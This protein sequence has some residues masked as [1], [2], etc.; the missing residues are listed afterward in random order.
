[1]S[2]VDDSDG[3][4]LGVTSLL[5]SIGAEVAAVRAGGVGV[6]G[7]LLLGRVSAAEL[8]VQSVAKPLGEM[9]TTRMPNGS[10]SC[11]SES[12]SPSTANFDALYHEKAAKERWPPIEETLRMVPGSF[13]TR[14]STDPTTATR[15]LELSERTEQILASRDWLPPMKSASRARVLVAL[16]S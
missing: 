6:V 2:N 11:A 4:A 16:E 14:C 10:T 5:P 12:D 3:S 13:V 15:P 7:D 1:M 9:S 8:P